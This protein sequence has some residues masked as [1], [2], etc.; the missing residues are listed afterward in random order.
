MIICYPDCV[1]HFIFLV[2]IKNIPRANFVGFGSLFASWIMNQCKKTHFQTHVI[3]FHSRKC[4]GYF[5]RLHQVPYIICCGISTSL[6]RIFLTKIC[7]FIVERILMEYNQQHLPQQPTYADPH[8][9]IFKFC[10]RTF[11]PAAIWR[12]SLPILGLNLKPL[13]FILTCKRLRKSCLSYK[14]YKW[15]HNISFSICSQ[16]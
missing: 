11:S 12:R 5:A 13:E 1:P 10:C 7:Q 9:V 4:R 6:Q 3:C 14:N 16:H 8:L 15:D 2:E